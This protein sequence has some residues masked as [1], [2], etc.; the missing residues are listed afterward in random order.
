[1]V[2]NQKKINSIEENNLNKKNCTIYHQASQNTS[3][4]TLSLLTEQILLS[5]I[6]CYPLLEK[7]D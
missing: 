7:Y 5:N 4:L 6:P 1:M 2:L 3:L